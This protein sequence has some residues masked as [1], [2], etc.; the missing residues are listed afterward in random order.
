MNIFCRRLSDSIFK[1]FNT[2][3]DVF[4]SKKKKLVHIAFK[5]PLISYYLLR[6]DKF[7]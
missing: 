1:K 4:V 6:T 3:A 2:E 7:Y 5:R